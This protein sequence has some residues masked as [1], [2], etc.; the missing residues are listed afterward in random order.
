VQHF[1]INAQGEQ[2]ISTTKRRGL[3]CLAYSHPSWF[4]T[5]TILAAD[6]KQIAVG[7][8]VFLCRDSKL[9]SAAVVEEVLDD[10]DVEGDPVRILLGPVTIRLGG[11]SVAAA[12]RA[13]TK[14][15]IAKPRIVNN[16]LTGFKQGAFCEQISPGQA[17]SL[18][19]WR[20]R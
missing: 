5:K 17:D 2:V 1:L 9:H 7:D 6:F 15:G 12:V 14:S 13:M 8:M 19:S 11:V 3:H 20:Q 18:L 10:H 16:R 4:G